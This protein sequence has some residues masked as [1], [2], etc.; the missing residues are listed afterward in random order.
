MTHLC[1]FLKKKLTTKQWR[2]KIVSWINI[3]K[4]KKWEWSFRSEFN[5]LCYEKAISYWIMTEF[6]NFL[7]DFGNL[8]IVI[9]ANEK[10]SVEDK[11]EKIELEK[12]M[13]S[14]TNLALFIFFFSWIL[15]FITLQLTSFSF[16]TLR[17]FCHNS[18]AH[19]GRVAPY[20]S[21]LDFWNL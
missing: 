11:T 20:L 21:V 16:S 7:T 5:T 10:L 6:R 14:L 2:L 3:E 17:C 19:R 12:I 18:H 4:L 8:L 1:W 13:S 9:R 15:I